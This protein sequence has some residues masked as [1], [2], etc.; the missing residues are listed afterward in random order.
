MKFGRHGWVLIGILLLGLFVRVYSISGQSYW[1]DEGSTLIMAQLNPL[2][3]VSE[4]A[5]R[6]F[7]PP[8]YYL[9]LHYWINLFGTSELSARLL[10][11]ILGFLSLLLMYS[12]GKV[13]FDKKVALLSSLLLALSVFHVEYSQEVRSYSL[14]AFLT[15]LSFYFFL[16]LFTE[17]SLRA[18][19]GYCVSSVIL[20]YTHVYGLFIIASQNIFFLLQHFSA[21][22]KTISAGKWVLLQAILLILFLP[23]LNPL[24]DQTK[25]S[26]GGTW[27]PV[28]SV[29]SV[30]YTFGGY[31]GSRLLLLFLLLLSGLAI[32]GLAKFLPHFKKAS[33]SGEPIPTEEG[34]SD[35]EVLSLLL[36][37]LATPI[38]LPFLISH[39]LKPVYISRGTIGGSFAFYL[40]VAK[41]IDNISQRY[42]KAAAIGLVM[43]LSLSNI[44]GY[45]HKVYKDP[46]REVAHYLDLNAKPGDLVWFNSFVCQYLYDHYSKRT[47][48]IETS[49]QNLEN[50]DEG[51][52]GQSETILKRHKRV[53]VIQSHSGRYSQRKYL[54]HKSYNLSYY[55]EYRVQKVASDYVGI[56]V[57]LYEG[58]GP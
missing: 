13:L 7:H 47:D 9:V 6:E 55:E 22:D 26:Q 24:L 30:I 33:N 8:V 56:R 36:I 10:S 54:L 34:L 31:A 19:I 27:V 29:R 48:L 17:K 37:W 53:W 15:L 32:I 50:V 16:K 14:M 28:P 41:G 35:L 1:Y 2:H 4:A 42:L 51:D 40:L 39:V 25:R 3:I 45:Y 23:W 52:A 21:R 57:S 38:V 43:I 46:W 20:M 11:A 44:W 12:A 49:A 58:Q 18:S 5:S